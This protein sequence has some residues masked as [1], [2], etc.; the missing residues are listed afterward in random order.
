M[1]DCIHALNWNSKLN[2]TPMPTRL[3]FILSALKILKRKFSLFCYFIFGFSMLLLLFYCDSDTIHVRVC[4]DFHAMNAPPNWF[5][6][7]SC[8]HLFCLFRQFWKAILISTAAWISHDGVLTPSIHA[9]IF[10]FLICTDRCYHPSNGIHLFIVPPGIVTIIA[11]YCKNIRW[12][13][14]ISRLSVCWTYQDMMGRWMQ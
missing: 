11:S 1:L 2:A 9:Q 6:G 14:N 8:E 7:I 10:L 13:G 3:T 12:K 5:N 4:V